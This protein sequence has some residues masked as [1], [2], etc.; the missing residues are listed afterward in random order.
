MAVPKSIIDKS[1]D[2]VQLWLQK[3][4]QSS[5]P[6]PRPIIGR[7][8][9]STL[10]AAVQQQELEVVEEHLLE[11]AHARLVHTDRLGGFATFRSRPR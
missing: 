1:I 11:A 6:E 10:L 5:H 3:Q 7:T 4:F 8:F 2:S 9:D